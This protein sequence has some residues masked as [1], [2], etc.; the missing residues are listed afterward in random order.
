MTVETK[1]NM[2]VG[3]DSSGFMHSPV[4]LEPRSFQRLTHDSPL[5]GTT[6][7]S[8]RNNRYFEGQESTSGKHSYSITFQ[9]VLQQYANVGLSRCTEDLDHTENIGRA[10][11]L[12]RSAGNIR[13]SSAK[14]TGFDSQETTSNGIIP[15]AKER[16][17]YTADYKYENGILTPPHAVV[18]FSTN[19]DGIYNDM[20]TKEPSS[21]NEEENS[22]TIH[23]G[24]K[25]K[26]KKRT[27]SS[28]RQRK[29]K[30]RLRQGRISIPST[31]VPY[32]SDI[33]LTSKPWTV[34]T[35][36][37]KNTQSNITGV[38]F[39]S[40]RISPSHV[41]QREN[42]SSNQRLGSDGSRGVGTNSNVGTQH[43]DIKTHI[44]DTNLAA[45]CTSVTLH[46]LETRENR[47]NHLRQHSA[48]SEGSALYDENKHLPPTVSGVLFDYS[49]SKPHNLGPV[50]AVTNTMGT[51]CS[52]DHKMFQ[53]TETTLSAIYGRPQSSYQKNVE[54]ARVRKVFLSEKQSGSIK[55][56]GMEI[57]CAPPVTPMPDMLKKYEYIP[58]MNDIRAQRAVKLKLQIMENH[59]R[60]RSEKK[61]EEYA[62][63][64]K[65]QLKDKERS[66]KAQQRME[67]YALNK[68]MTELENRRFQEFCKLNGINS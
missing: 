32:S 33:H 39:Y 11:K 9:E 21:N 38:R 24:G 1:S 67:I 43:I 63:V 6:S 68:E 37:S 10:D 59:T 13:T 2:Q 34:K 16:L 60:Q 52:S 65:Q 23:N 29:S 46:T 42:H 53:N 61:K 15:H 50:T 12:L 8:S 47:V 35:S 22:S 58:S 30:G 54:A 48:K 27:K 28:A 62:K 7:A 18:K 56:S 36:Q 51:N 26:K 57:P 31:H 25:A 19:Q 55:E 64:E 41:T 4:V 3:G 40:D 20:Y 14:Q 45:N 44:P 17:I 66:I 49:L 5:S